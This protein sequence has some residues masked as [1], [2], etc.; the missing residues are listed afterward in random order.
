MICAELQTRHVS[1]LCASHHHIVILSAYL[2]SP[3]PTFSFCL[4]DQDKDA[5]Y[6][7]GAQEPFRILAAHRED[8]GYAS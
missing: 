6:H 1:E 5:F 8:E 4:S 2:F 7:G 3:Y